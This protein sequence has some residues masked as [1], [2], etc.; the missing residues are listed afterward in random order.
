MRVRLALS[1][2]LVAIAPA[3]AEADEAAVSLGLG[4]APVEVSDIAGVY[5][6]LY[7]DGRVYVAG[8]PSSEALARFAEL[9]VT[10]V[11]NL[12]TDAEMDDRER[13]PFDEAARL[14]E[15]GIEYV[16]LPIGGEEEPF[17]PE[18]LERLDDVLRRHPGPVLLHC[19]VGWRASWVWTGYLARYLGLSLDEALERGEAIA[20]EPS[21]LEGLL[22]QPVHLE[23]GEPEPRAD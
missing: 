18:V 19:T 12:R 11:V 4:A 23:L 15:L 17:R 14:A 13:V 2:L 10:A 21:P 16:H 8:Q 5:R 9:G 6:N 20:L 1:T 7:R 3:L 22:G